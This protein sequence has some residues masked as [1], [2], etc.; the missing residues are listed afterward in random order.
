[1]TSVPPTH[2][3]STPAPPVQNP[4]NVSVPPP[5][6][7]L[8]LSKQPSKH[9]PR[10]APQLPVR[11][12]FDP[13]SEDS[14]DFDSEE[15]PD[16][17]YDLP[18]DEDS[19]ADDILPLDAAKFLLSK[20]RVDQLDADL[21]V[22]FKERCFTVDHLVEDLLKADGYFKARATQLKTALTDLRGLDL[23]SVIADF[24]QAV[25]LSQT[26][27]ELAILVTIYLLVSVSDQKKGG[28]LRC[29]LAAQETI[30]MTLRHRLRDIPEFLVSL[31]SSSQRKPLFLSGKPLDS[32]HC[33]A[34]LD[35]P[36]RNRE[37]LLMLLFKGIQFQLTSDDTKICDLAGLKAELLISG[38]SSHPLMQQ[39]E[40]NGTL[41]RAGSWLSRELIQFRKLKAA[42][43]VIDM[44]DEMP[45]NK[46][47]IENALFAFDD[48]FSERLRLCLR[49]N[50]VPMN[51]LKWAAFEAVVLRC[52]MECDADPVPLTIPVQKFPVQRPPTASAING[53]AKFASCKFSTH[54]H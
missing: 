29:A 21:F 24:Y 22:R 14:A 8:D 48:V 46:T 15:E 19:D 23:R 47:R 25:A 30:E 13:L 26:S 9:R 52:Q 4:T 34:I 37:K 54:A 18:S 32:A 35:T 38:D 41:E 12:L 50:L 7:L 44:L 20:F 27:S 16:S 6:A 28:R 5:S 51:Q 53:N 1:M 33:A 45:G 10:L 17:D 3:I 2:P 11:N 31:R 42:A 40:D 49:S 39:T 43:R 36:S